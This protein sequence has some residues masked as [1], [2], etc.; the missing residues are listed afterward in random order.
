MGESAVKLHEAYQPNG[1]R[2]TRFDAHFT[3]TAGASLN[4]VEGWF[5]LLNKRRIE[6]GSQRGIVELEQ[7]IPDDVASH[8]DDAIRVARER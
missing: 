4:S 2:A 7:A 8:H 3:P 1:G 5:A 6:C